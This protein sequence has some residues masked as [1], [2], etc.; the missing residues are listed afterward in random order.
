MLQ[1]LVLWVGKQCAVI[2]AVT[3]AVITVLHCTESYCQRSTQHPHVEKYNCNTFFA[4]KTSDELTLI[5]K[6]ILRKVFGFNFS[7][8][9]NTQLFMSGTFQLI[10]LMRCTSLISNYCC[11]KRVSF[12]KFLARALACKSETNEHHTSPTVGIAL[13]SSALFPRF[14]I[15]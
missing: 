7:G 12:S 15:E 11:M 3:G 13:I 1:W 14:C 9:S 10:F 5:Q 4:I 2:S 6:V 8:F